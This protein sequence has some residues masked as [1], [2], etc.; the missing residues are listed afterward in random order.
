V[1]GSRKRGRRG[2][3]SPLQ[4]IPQAWRIVVQTLRLSSILMQGCS[5]AA[6]S[7]RACG[8]CFCTGC[9]Q[10]YMW[11]VMRRGTVANKCF[12]AA[13]DH[14]DLLLRDTRGRDRH[15]RGWGCDV[16]PHV[17]AVSNLR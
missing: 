2:I 6:A 5:L 16:D 17:P 4:Q 8:E 13:L 11:L 14:P 10:V 3:L 7:S 15:S 1:P 9:F 12:G